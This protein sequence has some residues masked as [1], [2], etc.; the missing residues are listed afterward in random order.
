MSRSDGAGAP[1][2]A[3]VGRL[4]DLF[5]FAPIGAGAKLVEDGPAAV[6]RARQ[7][8]D[9]ARF[10]GRMVV[11][12]GV[13]QLRQRLA[14]QEAGRSSDV[15]DRVTPDEVGAGRGV[16]PDSDVGDASTPESASTVTSDDHR[17]EA[18]VA[19]DAESGESDEL[20]L[21]DYDHLPAIDIVGQLESLSD[22]ELDAIEAY[23]R[24]N[25]RRRTVLGKIAQ[26]RDDR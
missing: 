18:E 10:I 8:L 1:T 11:T 26:L 2:A 3:A 22:D 17:T 24:T 5:V 14:D 20:A 13:A 19:D 23:E 16:R 9:N 12:Q 7:E 4:L 6:S 25:R 15:A 21:P